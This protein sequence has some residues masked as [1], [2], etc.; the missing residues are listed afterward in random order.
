MTLLR[1]WYRDERGQDVVEYSLLLC[2]ITLASAALLTMNQKA[3]T[4]IWESATNSLEAASKFC[5]Q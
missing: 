5:A 1:A 2:F 4:V 3:V